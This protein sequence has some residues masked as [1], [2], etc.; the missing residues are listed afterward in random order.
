MIDKLKSLNN[1]N[2][3]VIKGNYYTRIKK[4]LD[5]YTINILPI[6]VDYRTALDIFERINTNSIA[7]TPS[8]ITYSLL[9]FGNNKMRRELNRKIKAINGNLFKFK[10]DFFIKLIML[11]YFDDSKYN[12]K[13]LEKKYR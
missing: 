1:N 5:K 7:L 10:I 11:I 6:N 3:K 2:V 8:E 9:I 4:V 13:N 12:Y